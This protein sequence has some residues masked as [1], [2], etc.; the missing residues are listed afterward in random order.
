MLPVGN[1]HH[2]AAKMVTRGA[3]VAL[4][5]LAALLATCATAS[6]QQ[7]SAQLSRR[8]A[9]GKVL[10]GRLSVAG[11]KIRIE[12]PNLPLGFFIVRGDAKATYFVNPD[13]EVFVDARQSSILTEILVPVDPAAP[14][15]QW[16]AMAEISG[17]AKGGA[18]WRCERV[19]DKTRN[20]RATVRYSITSPGGRHFAGWI[21]SQ[22]KFL[23][24]I[25]ADSGATLELADVRQAPQPASE[26]DIPAGFSKFDPQ[27]LVDQ[28]KHSDSYIAPALDSRAEPLQPSPVPDL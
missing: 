4:V 24:R 16:Q 14:C 25:E 19:G 28:M 6:A 15:V 20:G 21:D 3:G 12:Q 22:L 10:K 18:A 17:S 9:H 5:A 27:I 23:V 7:F 13:R 26:F 8:D 11:D 1:S 2:H